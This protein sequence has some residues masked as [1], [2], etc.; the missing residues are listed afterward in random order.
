MRR[1]DGQ[2]RGLA[3]GGGIESGVVGGVALS[4]ARDDG[5]IG[6]AGRGVGG[7]A[8]CQRDGR[9]VCAGRQCVSSRAG[10]RSQGAGPTGAAHRR[11]GQLGRQ[12]VDQRDGAGGGGPSGVAHGDAVGGAG[13]PLG[14][15][16]GMCRGDGQ[17]RGQADGGGIESG[18]V[19]GI[20]FQAAGDDRGIGDAGRGVGGYV[21]G[22]QDGRVIGAGRESVRSRAGEGGKGAVP[23]GAGHGGGS[24]LGGQSIDKGD[25]AAGW[26]GAGVG[27]CEGVNGAGL[28]LGEIAGVRRGDGQVRGKA[29]RGGIESRVVGGIGLPATGNSG[30]LGDVGRRAG[31]DVDG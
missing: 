10:E 2:V 13:L 14:E 20:G 1:G 26:A 11:G 3:D 8:H 4:A 9:V 21:H 23:A 6:D 27:H 24:Q 16:G 17:V 18:V 22:E 28:P 29:D 5:G 12:G 19:G 31:C 15:S 7:N 30:D 25:R